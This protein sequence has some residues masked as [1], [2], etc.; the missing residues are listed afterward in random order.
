VAKVTIIYEELPV[1]WLDLSEV[2]LAGELIHI[3]RVS[4]VVRYRTHELKPFFNINK[5]N[6]TGRKPN[7]FT[8]T[9]VLVV[10]HVGQKP[11]EQELRMLNL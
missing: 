9:V 1:A 4:F 7:D 8:Q 3:D 5:E 6:Y 11:S 10:D 2:P